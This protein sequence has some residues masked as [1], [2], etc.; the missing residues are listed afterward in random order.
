MKIEQEI[1]KTN[2]VRVRVNFKNAYDDLPRSKQ[3]AFREA[4]INSQGWI[5]RTP[6]YDTMSG[7]HLIK[8]EAATEIKELLRQF[9]AN[10]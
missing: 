10:I 5:S 7:R 9:G 8:P 6:F 2:L 1:T 3:P 4:V